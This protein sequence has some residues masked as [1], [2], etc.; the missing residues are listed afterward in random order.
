MIKVLIERRIADG[1]EEHYEN[2]VSE[3]LKSISS[4]PGYISGESL[5]NTDQPNHHVIISSWHSTNAW[6]KWATSEK[7]KYFKDQIMPLL[8]DEEKYT[9]FDPQH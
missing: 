1:L 2:Y 3:A 9:V 7:R 5:I 4:I 6:E 8:I